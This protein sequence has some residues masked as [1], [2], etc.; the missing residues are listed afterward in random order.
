MKTLFSCLSITIFSILSVFVFNACNQPKVP[1]KSAKYDNMQAL[2][3][4]EFRLAKDP[5]LNVIPTERLTEAARIRDEK[6]DIMQ[7]LSAPVSGINWTER[8]PSNIGGRTRALWFDL[9]DA[10]NGYKKVWA[11]GVAGGLWYTNDITVASPAWVKINDLFDNIA[12]TTFAQSTANNQHMYFGT[13]EGWYNVD[14][15]RGLGIWKS[16]NGGTT[17][18][19]LASTNNSTFHYVQKVVV[20]G[21][22]N[23]YACTF[24][25]GLQKSID[26]GT[27]WTKILGTGVGGGLA[28]NT[29]ISNVAADVEIAA[30]GDIYCSFGIFS[31]GKI[32]RSTDGGTNWTDITSTNTGRRIELACA[33]SNANIVYAL[34]HS[35]SDNNVSVISQYNAGTS[36]WTAGTVPTIIDQGSNSNFTRGQ[37]WYDLIAAVDPNDANSLYIGGVDA[38]RSDDAG[39]TWTQMT[40]WSLFGA[41]GFTSSQSVHAD[42]HA[43]VYA[44]GSSSRAIWGTD[45]GVYYTANANITGAGNKPT[46]SSKNTGYNVT[47]YYAGALHPSTTNYFLAGAQDNG[48]HK[49][50][51]AGV[52]SV[53]EVSGGDGAFCHIDQDNANI[54]ITSYVRNN[55]YVST[56]GG[57]NFTTRSKNNR[58]SFINPT[59]Y[60]NTANILYGGDDAGAYFRWTDPATN[61]ADAQVTV[62]QFSGASVTHITVSP[63]TANRVYFGLDNGS[64]V[65][66]DAANTGTSATGTVI[67][68]GTGAVSCVVI[69][70]ANEDHVLVTYSNYGVTSIFESTNATAGSPTW[71]S[72]EGDLSDMPVRWAMF[73]P[74]NSDHALIATELGVWSTNNLNPGGT[75]NWSPTNSGLANVRVDM[76]QYRSSDRTILA[77]THGRGAFTAVV[78]TVTTPDIDFISATTSATEQTATSASCR[79]Y[80]D[81]TVL[82]TIANAPTGSATVNLSVQGGG[83]ATQG[84]DY[85]FTTNGDFSSP[86]SSAI[87]AN[88]ATDSKTITIRIYNDAEVESSETF[89]LTYSISGSTN[90][91][92]GSGAQTHTITIT[93]NDA[94]PTGSSSVTYTIGAASVYLGNTT[95]GQPFDAKLQSKKNHFMYRASELIAAGMSAGNITSVALNIDKQSSRPFQSM[96][97]KM[98]TTSVNNLVDGSYTVASVS[99]VKTIA[100]YSTVA[101]WNSFTLDNAF[102]WDGTS[103]VVVEICYDNGTADGAQLTDRTLGYSDGGSASQGN[104]F[105]ENGINCSASFGSVTFYGTGYKPQ[106]RF[107]ISTTGTTVAASAITR[108]EYFGPNSDLYVYN[109]SGEI[110]AR[111]RNL[112]SHNYGCTDVIIDRAGTGATAFWNNNVANRLMDKTF[113]I[114]PTTNN[115]TGSY[116]VTL[117]YSQAEVNGWQTATGQS[118]NSI[119]LIKVAGQILSVTPGNGSAAGTVETVTPTRGTLGTNYTLT[120]TFNTGFSGFGAGIAGAALPVHLLDFTGRLRNNEVA[121]N[122]KTSSESN[123]KGFEIERSYDGNTFT[124]IGFV[125]AAGYSNSTLNYSFVDKSIAQENNFY[126]LKQVD[127]DN[128]SEYSKVVVIKNNLTAKQPFKL[129]QNPVKDNLDIQFA[130]VPNGRVIIKLTDITGKLI[131]TWKNDN[132]SLSRVRINI[133]DKHLSKGIYV[134]HARVNNKEYIEKIVKE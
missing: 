90:A 30:N 78:P 98:G 42:H 63:I 131:M 32:Y 109:N 84:V 112:S 39:A 56:D 69:D 10:A 6:L 59:D 12:I 22:G 123:S 16:S 4:Q 118:F 67:K 65:R 43:I 130:E 75:T 88:G 115:A 91:Q 124:K 2:I 34:F 3:E 14:A 106:V 55:Y 103:N 20:D 73:D 57:S 71:S 117:Y 40:T 83:T 120:Y 121:L 27:N 24:S 8:G 64:V 60:D 54:Q 104:M 100:S 101:G 80:R 33:P 18:S 105:W 41:T 108:S 38:L 7:S 53:T 111:V 44:P 102:S 9:A 89:T 127:L 37:A 125:P 129:L 82:M 21:S 79:N 94:A 110:L 47:Q 46:Y 107:G 76:L 50:T 128:K 28:G 62:A 51:G 70:P 87:F 15:V 11:A 95:A 52:N 114:V 35:T 19:Q 13:G 126:R 77:A 66:V 99:T 23:V 133:A 96:Q 74:R 68:T 81:Y 26:G 93:D 29:A 49:F 134:L 72:V 48:T 5:Q 45:G 58:G 25:G 132:V 97:I 61:G 17:W 116:Q 85:D 36:T 92:A 1:K 119:Q 113:R 86:S 122:W 31:T